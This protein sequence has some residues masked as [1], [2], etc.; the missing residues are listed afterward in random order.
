MP[1]ALYCRVYGTANLARA[2]ARFGEEGWALFAGNL[3]QAAERVKE[4]VQSRYLTVNSSGPD[5]RGA[6]G[7][8]VRV[9]GAR[10]KVVGAAVAQSLRRSEMPNLRRPNYAGRMLELA[11]KPAL[12]AERGYVVVKAKEA[13]EEA[14]ALYWRDS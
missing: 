5:T 10:S 4:G 9:A 3:A 12:Q 6:D 2:A 14:K 1:P 8:V 7:V 11:F 13:L